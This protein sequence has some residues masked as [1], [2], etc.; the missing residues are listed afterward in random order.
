MLPV[1]IG[2]HYNQPEWQGFDEYMK[3]QTLPGLAIENN[4]AFSV[5]DGQWYVI[6][7]DP[8]A[9]AYLIRNNN[10]EIE[11]TVYEGGNFLD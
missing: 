5:V 1:I 3:G 9:K 4:T 6:H 11:K 7:A 2:P 8:D 10:G